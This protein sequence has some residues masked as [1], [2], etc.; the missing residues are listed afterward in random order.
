LE[1]S[2]DDSKEI[3]RYNKLLPYF[4]DLPALYSVASI[5]DK[6]NL[7]RGI[8]WGGFTKEK[9]GARTRTLNPMFAVNHLKIKDLL[10][11]ETIKKSE[12]ISGFPFCTLQPGLI[13]LFG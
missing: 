5:D 7:L 13:E 4:S 12:N 3:E 9:E 8:F 6:Q 1:L 11:V 10:R 2:K